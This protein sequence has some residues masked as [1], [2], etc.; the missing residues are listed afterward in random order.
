MKLEQILTLARRKIQL[1]RLLTGAAV[2]AIGG[3][4]VS[5]LVAAVLSRQNFS[6]AAIFW[7]RIGAALGFA[8]ALWWGVV[9]PLL[10]TP[11]RSRI[12]LFLEERYPELHQRLS[13]AVEMGQAGGGIHPDIR[14]LVLRDAAAYADRLRYPRFFWPRRSRVSALLTVLAVGA[15]MTLLWLGPHEY[16][17]SWGTLLGAGWD[18]QGAGLYRIEV[19]PGNAT[20]AE[21]ADLEVRA[22]LLGFESDA[23]NL[24]ARYRNHPS[25][26]S[27]RMQVD[28]GDQY[29]F[30]FYDIREPLDYYVEADGIRSP[31]YRIEVADVPRVKQVRFILR[32]PAYTGLSETVLED[33]T[34]IRALKGTEV[35]VQIE[36]DPHAVSGDLQF[37]I[38]GEL[39]LSRIEDGRFSVTFRIDSDDYFR[40]R[41]TNPEG[42]VT[43]AA[44]EFTVEALDDQKPLLSFLT[45]GRDK[46]VTNLE[47]VFLELKAEDDFGIRELRFRYAVNGGA[48]QSVALGVP[49]PGRQFTASH[50][51]Y[52][53][54]LDL[55]PGDFV[56][57]YG[58]AADAAGTSATDMYFLEV[59]PF[60]KEYRQSQMNMAGGAGQQRGL[61]LARQ[62]KQ[63]VVAT[64][65]LIQE[66]ER[67]T[68]EERSENSQTL[69]L[70]QQR[71]QGQAAAIADRV[72][73]RGAAMSDPRFRRMLEY[74]R[75][76]IEHMK[77]AEAALN[78][79]RPEEALPEEQKAL[80]QLLRA[81]ALFN[82]VQVSM[83]NS[84]DGGAS[85]EDLA[86]LVDLELDRT[87]NQYETL[88]QRREMQQDQALDEAL[89]KLKELAKRQEQQAERLRRQAQAGSGGGQATQQELIEEM[90]RLARELARL[91]RQRQDPQMSR[92]GRELER[93]ARDLRNASASNRSTAESLQA[94]QQAAERLKQ[95][96]DAL[97]HQRESE[98]HRQVQ[99]LKEEAAGLVQRQEQLVEDL[100]EVKPPA[101]R[102]E[103]GE[104]F[105]EQLRDLYWRKQGLQQDLQG[106]ETRLHQAARRMAS[107]EPATAEKLKQAGVGIRDQ[108][109]PERMQESSEMLAAG[110]VQMAERREEAVAGDLRE[111]Q[112]QIDDAEQALGAGG[113]ARPE[114]RLRQALAEAGNLTE[115]LESLKARAEE[116]Q[117][118]QDPAAPSGRPGEGEEGESGTGS[119]ETGRAAGS[120]DEDSRE[121]ASAGGGPGGESRDLPETTTRSAGAGSG[122]GIDPQSAGR[123]WRERLREADELRRQLEGV[124][125]GLAAEVGRLMRRMRELD[126]E[127]ILADPAEVTRLKSQII[128]GFHQ[129]ELQ[130]SRLLREGRNDYL[131]PV[132]EDEVPPEFR[133]RVDEYYR[134]L[135]ARR[136]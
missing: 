65:S 9:R 122:G 82:E 28:A 58:W 129:L 119:S 17:Y 84:P 85:P 74:M 59:E 136:R 4:V 19:L 108:R 30:R 105:F 120:R 109:I 67:Y 77:P 114:D 48:E 14:R 38:S 53:E 72:E 52:L 43:P 107:E 127:K 27:V 126:L 47:E 83:S 112:S 33:Q 44:D 113:G 7:C 101:D 88:Q 71:L 34:L 90:E 95:A 21:R 124:D 68:R 99:E 100:G 12:A 61:D 70:I 64:F 8:G 55:Q 5:I 23:V 91:S 1:E 87:K 117:T 36:A 118:G 50:T 2:L 3:L 29:L 133:E 93:A 24:F 98:V 79:V 111:L 37:E 41:L 18:E 6:E 78:L 31:E 15:A 35:E 103:P 42:V 92:V 39:P 134:R 96:Q 89:E 69:A 104:A 22:T 94:A 97:S 128:D 123:E 131:R 11:S 51:L 40:I 57:Y 56:S 116:Q 49:R 75:Q 110:L 25:W 10:T 76:A 106:L 121:R 81:E 125:P 63:V 132:S 20:V 54:E 135:A 16:R 66:R 73:R 130:I 26:E 45:P 60:D 86:D 102:E 115:K 32:F 62:Q 46:P 80:Q 13:A